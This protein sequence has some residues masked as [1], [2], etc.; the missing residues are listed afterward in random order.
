M[1]KLRENYIAEYEEVRQE[2]GLS[3]ALKKLFKT[4]DFQRYVKTDMVSVNF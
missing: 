1:L 3:N 4:Y 2:L